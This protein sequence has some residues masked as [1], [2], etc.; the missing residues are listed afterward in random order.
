[1]VAKQT[2]DVIGRDTYVEIDGIKN[3]PAK[4]D[5]GAFSSAVWANSIEIDNNKILH[6]QLFDQKS[7][8]YTGKTLSRKNYS[9]VKIRSSNGTEQ[10]RYRT[11]I[12][13]KI[14]DR[15]IRATFT[16]ADRSR[17]EYP[18]LIGCRALR[19]KFIVDVSKGDIK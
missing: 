11:H 12:P 13:I 5:T 6:F 10:I 16:L 18:V 7:P 9:V 1:M 19:N 3:V 8:F 15:L 4:I 14:H 17:N 2:K